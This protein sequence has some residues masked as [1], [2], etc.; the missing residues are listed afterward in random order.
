MNPVVFRNARLVLGNEVVEGSLA[1]AGGTIAS[2]DPGHRQLS[3]I[4]I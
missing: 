2:I 3:L 1:A 4:H